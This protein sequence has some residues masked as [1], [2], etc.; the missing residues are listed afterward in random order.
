MTLTSGAF[1]NK[2]HNKQTSHELQNNLDISCISF[3][4]PSRK[5]QFKTSQDDTK[6]QDKTLSAAAI[7]K[8]VSRRCINLPHELTCQILTNQSIKIGRSAWPTREHREKCQKQLP[9][10]H[11]NVKAGWIFASGVSLKSMR[12]IN[13]T[14]FICIFKKLNLSLRSFEK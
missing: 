2:K 10:L 6:L 8:Q 13:T 5:R 3:C 11:V 7:S 14:Y 1:V 9:S 12:L 4:K